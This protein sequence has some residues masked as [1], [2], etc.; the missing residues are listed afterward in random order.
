MG[1]PVFEFQIIRRILTAPA[2]SIANCSGGLSTQIAQSATA[3]LTLVRGRASREA[4]GPR[5]RKLLPSYNCLWLW[6][7]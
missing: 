2:D 6:M 4:Y 3:E 1:N 7:T 5:H